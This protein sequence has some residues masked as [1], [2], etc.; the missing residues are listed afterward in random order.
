VNE[1]DNDSGLFFVCHL[2]LQDLRG[3]GPPQYF[4]HKNNPLA[5]VSRPLVIFVAKECVA[6]ARVEQQKQGV[7][8][9]SMHCPVQRGQVPLVELIIRVKLHVLAC[10]V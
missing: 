1:V 6:R 10:F 4:L 3:F 2:F 8:I 7:V 5:V 9:V